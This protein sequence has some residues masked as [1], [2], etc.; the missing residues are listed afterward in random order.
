M[1]RIAL[2]LLII[3]AQTQLG[4][5]ALAQE[6]PPAPPLGPWRPRAQ[7]A[8]PEPSA[9][10]A[11]TGDDTYIIAV[12]VFV[13][14]I[15]AVTFAI[16]RSARGRG[17]SP[18]MQTKQRLP[19]VLEVEIESLL[20][21]R[22]LWQKA[23]NPYH[24]SFPKLLR[25]LA[26]FRATLGKTVVVTSKRPRARWHLPIV[27]ALFGSSLVLFVVGTAFPLLEQLTV[28]GF[29]MLLAA[30]GF[31]A[32]SPWIL[33]PNLGEA[34]TSDTRAPILCLRA[35]KDD[36]LPIST[37]SEAEP[38][39]RRLELAVTSGL[40]T[41]GPVIAIGEPGEKMPDVGAARGYLSTEKWKKAVT[42]WMKNALMIVVLPAATPG[43]RWELKRV[44]DH[45]H[46]LKL[47]ILLPPLE[48]FNTADEARKA[49][50]WRWETV[51]DCLSSTPF[52]A[53]LQE[54]MDSEHA[55]VAVHFRPD[56]GVVVLKSRSGL[57]FYKYKHAVWLA[58]Y[59]IFCHDW[60]TDRPRTFGLTDTS[61]ELPDNVREYR[62]GLFRDILQITGELSDPWFVTT[63][64][65][66]V[67]G[68]LFFLV[69]GLGL[70]GL[71]WKAI[72]R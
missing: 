42:S 7:E 14:L 8:P 72:F 5:S 10:P 53:A 56:G 3:A 28:L 18:P 62:P 32:A 22:N 9:L 49:R 24:L 68:G 54:V 13:L 71:I 51:L 11:V 55:A 59:G 57:D 4:L 31:W 17:K 40:K 16:S 25:H 33:Q 70:L 23:A 48:L 6:A 37:F 64:I 50:R 39:D 1:K 2:S 69:V 20:K 67:F 41:L 61:G 27:V 60:T 66:L 38:E 35:F 26:A 45:N 30:A 58:V 52:F 34:L 47:V 46:L 19:S 12:G 21:L 29:F 43:L 36:V 65:K 63:M 15:G 44:V